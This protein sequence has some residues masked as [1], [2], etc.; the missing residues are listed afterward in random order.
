MTN[1][2]KNSKID[3]IFTLPPQWTPL[4]PYYALPI[5]TGEMKKA[6]Y[7]CVIKDLNIDFFNRILSPEFLSWCRITANKRLESLEFDFYNALADRGVVVFSDSTQ[8]LCLEIQ[9]KIDKSEL[10]WDIVI[11]NINKA[12]NMLKDKEEFYNP[13]NMAWAF[14][15]IMK[16]LEIASLPYFPSKIMLRDFK[17]RNHKL[18]M[19]SVIEA[20]NNEDENPFSDYYKLILPSFSELNPK[21]IGISINAFSQV[22]SGL[23]LAKLLKDNLPESHISIGGNF[24]TRVTATLVNKPDFFKYFC[25]SLIYEEG[26]KPSLKLIEAIKTDGDLSKVPNI[27]YLDN[28]KVIMTEKCEPKKLDEIAEPDLSGIDLDAYLSPEIV[29]PIQASRGC[30]WGKCTFCDHDFG[31]N[32]NL[33]SCEK[34]IF[35]LKVLKEKYGIKHFEFID[36]SISPSYMKKMSQ[37][38]LDNNLDIRWFMYARTEKGFSQELLDLAYKAGCRMIMW[39]VESGS[40]RI[41][42]LINKGIDLDN[43]FEPLKRANAAKIWNFCFTFFGFPTETAEEAMESINMIMDNKNIINSYGMSTFSLGK[44]TKLREE[45]ENFSIVNIREDEEDLSI[46][47]HYDVLKGMT[48]NQII[49]ATELCTEVSEKIYHVPLWFSIGFREFLHLYLDKWGFDYVQKYSYIDPQKAEKY[50]K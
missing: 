34:L 23:T 26:E 3:I 36:E 29:L 24:F 37:A 44:H 22:V 35:E 33:K 6:G 7:S 42:E 17:N 20:I 18:T 9:D 12:K 38:I 8:N 13:Q 11:K 50:K 49:K 10:Y 43:R 19:E 25:H 16:A 30:Y 47:L 5:L 39:G 41:M 4:S 48:P 1:E 28:E 21:I 46:K 27:L 40:K 31:V 45:P 2:T 14:N 15:I 32:Y